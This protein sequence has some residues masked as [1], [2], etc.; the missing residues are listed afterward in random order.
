[1]LVTIDSR[2]GL[3]YEGEIKELLERE[4]IFELSPEEVAKL[5]TKTKILMNLGVPTEIERYKDFTF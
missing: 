3:V 2:S 5:K 4:K 1:M